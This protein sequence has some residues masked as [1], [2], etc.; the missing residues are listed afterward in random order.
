MKPRSLTPLWRTPRS[1]RRSTAWRN[2]ACDSAKAR[3]CT[4]PGSVGVR[5]GSGTR[6]SLVK[7]VISRPSP[8]SKY[9]WLSDGLSRLGC[10]KMNGIPSAPSQKSIEV[11]RSA[12]TIVMWWTPWLCSLRNTVS[13]GLNESALVVAA[14]QAPPRD[15][16]DARRDDERVTQPRGDRL[17]QIRVGL[18]PL[19]DLDADR[20]RRVLLDARRRGPDEDVAA[21]AR[22]ERADHL[23]HGGREDVDAADDEQVVGAPDAPDPRPRPPARG[24]RRADLDV[25]ARA[26]P[27]QWRGAV[28]QM[29]EHE[30][31]GRAVLHGDRLAARRVDE[32]GV[33]EAVGAEV[34][35]VLVLALAPQ[36]HADVAD[37]HRLGHARAPPLLEHGAEGGLAA[38]GLAGD[39]HALDAGA[40]QVGLLQQMGGVGRREHHRLGLERL[41]GA[42]DAF[43]VAGAD[44]DVTQ[45][46][47]VEAPERGTGHERPSVVDR[48]DALARL[49]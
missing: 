18:R 43:G 49:D 42:Q 10:S 15:E 9:R 29:G 31:A 1:S 38:T 2:V 5:S 13:L 19:G 34:H 36:R 12:P 21:D 46:E 14:L 47:A 27:Q 8:G 25:V 37:A 24:R 17:R 44:G 32:L 11:W 16:L 3:W 30:L 35:A 20:Q 41:D 33:D 26:E 6:S 22:R 7:I 23:A 40:A 45:A 48:D 39:E 28:A 4:Q